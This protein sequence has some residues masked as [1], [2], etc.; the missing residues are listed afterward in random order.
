[1]LIPPQDSKSLVAVDACAT[2]FSR[3][4]FTI[5][6]PI[7]FGYSISAFSNF[8]SMLLLSQLGIHYLAA[9][10]L[11][12][13]IF[14]M[15]I[16]IAMSLFL[17]MANLVTLARNAKK[18]DAI[19]KIVQQG[20]W[21]ATVLGLIPL[22][23]LFNSKAILLYCQQPLIVAL[24]CEQFFHASSYGFIPLLW[25]IILGQIFIGLNN[26]RAYFNFSLLHS[27]LGLI[28]SYLLMFGK[29]GLPRLEIAGSGYAF[30]IT[31]TIICL[32]ELIYL[33]R[34]YRF[35]NRHIFSWR[36]GKEQWRY[37]QAILSAGYTH[38]LQRSSEFIGL[39]IITLLIGTWGYN[40]L[41]A[42]QIAVQILSLTLIVSLGMTQASGLL[43]ARTHAEHNSEAARTY[44][45][46]SIILS[47]L[48][49][50][51]ICASCWFLPDAIINIFV[52]YAALSP[53]FIYLAK[54]ILVIAAITQL[55]ENI[56]HVTSGALRGLGDKQSSLCANL[57]SMCVVSLPLAWVFG[58]M[59]QGGAIGINISVMI[60]TSISTFW[61]LVRFYMISKEEQ[62]HAR[63]V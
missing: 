14:S 30:S 2:H 57:T 51:P 55:L 31:S 44:G 18:F 6:M 38:C 17:P 46:S 25:T 5:A 15:L 52:Q 43:V 50:L 54:N 4:I 19:N 27:C 24:L 62:F 40:S 9:G 35:A 58:F 61:V 60:G 53:R 10:A 39:T 45:I 56:R 49:I 12:Y 29:L 3:K 47:S 26:T 59:L 42:Q 34:R 28:L 7:M 33:Y 32:L 63:A 41:A 13:S 23:I 1:M 21:L 11:I 16:A 20:L 22:L 8:C 36:R 37:A 48:L